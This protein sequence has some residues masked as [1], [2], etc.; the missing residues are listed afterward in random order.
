M[1]L[2][3]GIV[4]SSA[5]A[6]LGLP[7]ALGWA[8]SLGSRWPRRSASSNSSGTA[9]RWE[10]LPVQERIHLAQAGLRSPQRQRRWVE[11][12]QLVPETPDTLSIFFKSVDRLPLS[13]FLP[14]QHLIVERP[15]HGH[16]PSSQ[17]CYT[18]SSLP[19]AGR[20]RITVRRQAPLDDGESFSAWVHREWRV[21]DRLFVRGP[22][23]SFVLDRADTNK[24]VVF[25][26]AG[27]GITPMATMLQH[28]LG[29]PS[30]RP[31]WLYYQAR[32][33]HQ[34]PL[35]D[36]LVQLIEPAASCQARIYLSQLGQTTRQRLRNTQILPG[37]FTASK[38]LEE[39]GSSDVHVMMCGPGG[40]MQAMRQA[41]V[42]AGVP[43]AQI[44]EESFGGEE[45]ESTVCPPTTAAAT[46]DAPRFQIAFEASHRAG[47]SCGSEQT[48]L[49]VAKQHGVKI[50]A[51]CRAGHCGTCAVRLL[52]GNVRYR[53]PPQAELGEDEIL[54]CVCVAESDLAIYA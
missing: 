54:P 41:L 47:A 35:M 9:R 15:A 52:Q 6:V 10:A 3:L 28:E 31:A 22:R 1:L 13:A 12:D 29:R 5:S 50:P 11:I 44:H 53:Q 20:W 4:A 37:K 18:L 14:G 34:A 17:R 43:A 38:V 42:A 7:A 2:F 16:F 36:E 46:T 30:S 33:H 25:L 39:V 49:E 26:A 8:G 27:V 48:L 45:A 21:G 24:P 19:H 32:Q 23:G 51:S 40:W